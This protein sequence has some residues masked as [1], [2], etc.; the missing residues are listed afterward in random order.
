MIMMTIQIEML[1]IFI[2]SLTGWIWVSYYVF[3]SA[4]LF[5][6]FLNARVLNS[7]EL[8]GYT[9]LMRSLPYLPIPASQM[10]SPHPLPMHGCVHLCSQILKSQL[11]KVRRRH[12]KTRYSL[13][14]GISMLRRST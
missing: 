10:I 14:S 11:R 13:D 2:C 7:L 4:L 12:S 8:K 6:K 3:T 9:S 5:L 1:M